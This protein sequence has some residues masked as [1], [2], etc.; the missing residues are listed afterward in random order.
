[1]VVDPT[2][3]PGGDR[4]AY[5]VFGSLWIGAVDDTLHIPLNAFGE[6]P[7]WSPDDT[8]IAYS[9]DDGHVYVIPSTG[10]APVAIAPGRSPAWS[11]DGQW[12]AYAGGPSSGGDIRIVPATGG[13]PRAV[14]QDAAND[15]EPSWS[16]DGR[17]LAFTSDRA[18]TRTCGSF[19][20]TT[21]RCRG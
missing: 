10:G 18:A 2:W 8:R 11:P 19:A 6:H 15:A 20:S 3:S 12:I 16:P 1:V 13:E 17:F 7:A 5:S 21:A 9:G 14:T 4:I